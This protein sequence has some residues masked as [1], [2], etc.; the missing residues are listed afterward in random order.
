MN[1]SNGHILNTDKYEL[2]SKDN[3]IYKAFKVKGEGR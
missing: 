3:Q 2:Y 1:Y